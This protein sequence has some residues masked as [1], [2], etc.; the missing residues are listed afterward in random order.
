[1]DLEK[2][3]T[4]LSDI[5]VDGWFLCNFH[6]RDPIASRILGIPLDSFSTRRWFYFIP[7]KGTPSKLVSKVEKK[8]LDS[9]PGET[10]DFFSWKQMHA[11]IKKMLSGKKR[12]ALNYSPMNH[13]PYVSMVDGGTIDLLK[14]FG[15]ELVSSADLIQIFDATLTKAAYESHQ[16]AGKKVLKIKNEAFKKIGDAIKNKVKLS[17]YALQQFIVRR[18]EEEGL[19]CENHYPIVGINGHPADPHFEPTVE[20]STHFKAGDLVLIDLW[21]KLKERDSI[22][23][24]ITWCGYIGKKPPKVYNKIFEVVRDARNAAKE[25]VIKCFDKKKP[26]YGYK[27]DDV[28]RKVITEAGYGNNFIHRTGHSIGTQVHGNGANIDNLETKDERRILPNSCFSL[29]PGIYIDG[30]LGIRSEIN[31][32]VTTE[33]EVTVYGEEQDQLINISV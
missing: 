32:F 33:G 4:A 26:C 8:A 10:K 2:I 16:A 18:F 22:Y 13:I 17:E 11:G 25:Y 7:T 30:E 12:I 1:M 14:S 20:N 29:E 23:F 15:C 28:C 6:N 9:L 3:Q 19:T 21:A 24:D 5:D 27:V 31:V